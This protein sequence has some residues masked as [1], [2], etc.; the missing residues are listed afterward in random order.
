MYSFYKTIKK[1]FDEMVGSAYSNGHSL[2]RLI[3]YI[4]YRS[5]NYILLWSHLV[6]LHGQRLP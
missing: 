4:Y 5:N 2:G 1:K 3:P 6:C